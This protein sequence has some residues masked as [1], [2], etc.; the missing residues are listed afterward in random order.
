LQGPLKLQGTVSGEL[1]GQKGLDVAATVRTPAAAVSW[2]GDVSVQG[3]S[4]TADARVG[5]TKGI[6]APPAPNTNRP[7]PKGVAFR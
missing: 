1:Y 4:V 5:Q 6:E 7:S 3:A 2:N